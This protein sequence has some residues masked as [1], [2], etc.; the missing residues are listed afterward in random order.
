LAA[1][2]LGCQLLGHQRRQPRAAPALH[3]RRHRAYPTLTIALHGPPREQLDNFAD[4]STSV[5]CLA[6]TGAL[7]GN[8]DL[9]AVVEPFPAPPANCTMRQMRQRVPRV[10]Q[11]DGGHTLIYHTLSGCWV[12]PARVRPLP[13]GLWGLRRPRVVHTPACPAACRALSAVTCGAS[14]ATAWV[15][16]R[17]GLLAGNPCSQ[18]A[19]LAAA[20]QPSL[21]GAIAPGAVYSRAMHACLAPARCWGVAAPR[22]GARAGAPRVPPARP[23]RVSACDSNSASH[24]SARTAAHLMSR[25]GR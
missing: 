7:D 1:C 3:G 19:T 9:R 15:S 16:S 18:Q 17:P 8:A 20:G 2:P 4:G 24:C 25:P 5:G 11:P 6:S 23:R 14:L 12:D 22:A 10:P 21:C 13:G